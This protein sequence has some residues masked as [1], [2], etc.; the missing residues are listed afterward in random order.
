MR[1]GEERGGLRAALAAL[2]VAAALAAAGGGFIALGGAR[3]AT[4][5]EGGGTGGRAGGGAAAAAAESA[6]EKEEAREALRRELSEDVRQLEAFSRTFRTVAKLVSPS[7]V[8]IRTTREVA[9]D[10]IAIA[11]FGDELFRRFFGF[12][13]FGEEDEAPRPRLRPRE[14]RKF[15]QTSEGSGVI[16]SADGKILTNNHVV[17]GA[18]K[19]EVRLADGRTLEGKVLGTDP[20][21]DLALLRVEATGLVA[22]EL[23]D[24][25]QLAVG[26]WVMAIGNPFGLDHTVTAGIVSAVG[27]SD[28]GI[29]VYEDFIQTDAAIN[30]GNSGGPLVNLRGEVVGINTAIKSRTGGF[31]GIGFA[32]PIDMAK[33]VVAQLEKHGR[34][35]RGWLGVVIQDLTPPLARRF[36][37][38]PGRGTLVAD[39]VPNGPADGAGLRPGDVIVAWNG[40]PIEDRRDLQNAV[41]DTRPGSEARV[42]YVRDGRRAEVTVEVGELPPEDEL[43]GGGPG[44]PREEEPRAAE[45]VGIEVRALT[46]AIARQ[47]GLDPDQK[48]VVVTGVEPGSP[49]AAHGLR[50][51]DV[52]EEVNRQPTL[53]LESFDRAMRQASVEEGILF[54]V[55]R[56]ERSSYVL[57]RPD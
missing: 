29:T 45:R 20:R 54:R 50:S 2:V 7:V 25:A 40:R 56:G 12:D 16:I 22:A 1:S 49:A 24:S 10:G 5:E 41:A 57:V 28:V 18:T 51:G 4:G 39:V 26:D 27:R 46:P 11:P 35:S 30:P 14:Q 52:I 53:D 48:G 6:A 47:L 31:L 13:P 43:A 15:V 9:A 17:A 38:E 32:I 55:R 3:S 8:H 33:K 19:I 42:A 36:G 23:G 37:V 34:V 21:T 44:R